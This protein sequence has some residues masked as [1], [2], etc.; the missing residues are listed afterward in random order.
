MITWS[1]RRQPRLFLIAAS[2]GYLDWWKDVRTTG[3]KLDILGCSI[4]GAGLSG[5]ASVE[6]RLP[7]SL[8][9]S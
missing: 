8:Q 6:I 3:S 7:L 1:E 9:A 5:G 4:D 2:H